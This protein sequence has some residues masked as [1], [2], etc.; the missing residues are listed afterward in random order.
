MD[1]AQSRRASLPR[2]IPVVPFSESGSRFAEIAASAPKLC[3]TPLM[4]IQSRRRQIT[5]LQRKTT[6]E[7]TPRMAAG[8]SGPSEVNCKRFV[9]L[10]SCFF[11]DR[12]PRSASDLAAGAS[13]EHG[14]IARAGA[15]GLQHWRGFRPTCRSAH[16]CTSECE[17]SPA[18]QLGSTDARNVGAGADSQTPFEPYNHSLVRRR[19]T[20]VLPGLGIT[21]G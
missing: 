7:T 9:L 17:I 2:R 19:E 21:I 5:T 12:F 18:S 1:Q 14:A 20:S 16:E 4:R 11:A 6:P 15:I 13:A 10:S 3:S 8:D